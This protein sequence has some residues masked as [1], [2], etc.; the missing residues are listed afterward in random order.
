MT[1]FR[2]A[3]ERTIMADFIRDAVKTQDPKKCGR[4]AEFYRFRCGLN[5]DETF[6]R[7]HK[8]TGIELSEWETLLYDS[9]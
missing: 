2:A 7:V 9:E 1:S 4:I 8:L 6:E 3:Y 5:Y